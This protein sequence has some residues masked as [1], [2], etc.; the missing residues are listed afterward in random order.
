[1]IWSVMLLSLGHYE[2]LVNL[3]KRANF[4]SDKVDLKSLE[5]DLYNTGIRPERKDVM[6]TLAAVLSRHH[7]RLPPS[8]TSLLRCF[9]VLEGITLLAPKSS[10]LLQ[11]LQ[12]NITSQ[13]LQELVRI[14]GQLAHLYNS[15]Q[16]NKT[17][18][19]A[20]CY[21]QIHENSVFRVPTPVSQQAHVLKAL[22]ITIEWFVGSTLSGN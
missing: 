12:V 13:L 9:C 16:D 2:G 10:S 7:L 1:M 19:H 14:I 4:L 20:K 5:N 22:L 11:C 18:V 6:M 3:F 17:S 8:F 21:Q 15:V